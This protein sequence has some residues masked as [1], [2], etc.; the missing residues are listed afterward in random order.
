MGL[1]WICWGITKETYKENYF[2][3]EQSW[4]DHRGA[5]IV[6]EHNLGACFTLVQCA[7]VVHTYI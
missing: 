2:K 4:Y 5:K 6:L 7:P 3:G 1:L